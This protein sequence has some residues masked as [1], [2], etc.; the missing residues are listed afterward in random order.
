MTR[1]QVTVNYW[2]VSNHTIKIP[3]SR[4]HLRY[5]KIKHQKLCQKNICVY[6]CIWLMILKLKGL[7]EATVCTLL[8]YVRNDYLILHKCRKVCSNVLRSMLLMPRLDK[9]IAW[10]I[11]KAYIYLAKIIWTLKL[12]FAWAPIICFNGFSVVLWVKRFA[13]LMS[14]VSVEYVRF[15]YLY[16]P[17]LPVY[18]I[19]YILYFHDNMTW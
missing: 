1:I 10:Y 18:N 13:H 2:L 19:L 12:L 5:K 6:L 15:L 7:C 17:H 4:W 11:N 14:Q 16:S 8:M 9:I 3:H